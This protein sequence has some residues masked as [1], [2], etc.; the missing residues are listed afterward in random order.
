MAPTD[1]G[2]LSPTQSVKRREKFTNR[3][4]LR[5]LGS[6]K[7][8]APEP[9]N[10]T[11][12]V[13]VPNRGSYVPLKQRVDKFFKEETFSSRR[14]SAK[15]PQMSGISTPKGTIS[16]FGGLEK[17]LTR[18]LDLKLRTMLRN[19]SV[20]GEKKTLTSEELEL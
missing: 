14:G 12:A 7:K 19:Q 9:F 11:Q 15:K 2:L 13:A 4:S 17:T 3:D 5:L 6:G 8:T 18:P 10:L 20:D 16:Q 1:E